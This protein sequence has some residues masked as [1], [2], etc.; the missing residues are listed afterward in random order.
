M[1]VNSIFLEAEVLLCNFFKK[2]FMYLFSEGEKGK[3][4]EWERNVN[5]WLP[6]AYPLLGTWPTTQPCALT[7]N[8]T[9]NPLVHRPALNPLSHT[10]QGTYHVTFI[11]RKNYVCIWLFV[12]LGTLD[13][14]TSCLIANL[15]WMPGTVLALQG[16]SK[17]HL[18]PQGACGEVKQAH[19]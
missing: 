17:A 12:C 2:D 3:E 13:T 16:Q 8:R 15:W 4:K 10:S 14:G 11:I 1:Y 18:R 7:G 19:G 9:S 5:V 6:I